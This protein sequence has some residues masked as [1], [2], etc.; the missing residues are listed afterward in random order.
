MHDSKSGEWALDKREHQRYLSLALP[1]PPH[2]ALEASWTLWTLLHDGMAGTAGWPTEPQ[3]TSDPMVTS[4]A[5][6][7]RPRVEAL[8]THPWALELLGSGPWQLPGVGGGEFFFLRGGFMLTPWGS[9]RWGTALPSDT[10]LPSRGEGAVRELVVFFCGLEWTH[11]ITLPQPPLRRA[12][13]GSKGGSTGRDPGSGSER[14]PQ[15]RLTERRG[16]SSTAQVATLVPKGDAALYVGGGEE[17]PD[18]AAALVGRCNGTQE[19]AVTLRRRLV[20]TG[21][22]RLAGVGALYLLRRGVAYEGRDK[23]WGSWSCARPP[24]APTASPR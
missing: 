21:P 19:N 6:Y 12:R 22:Y 11:S 4:H 23:A 8:A 15:V 24:T 16:S 7:V 17:E 13:G 3:R 14:T 18:A 20:G 5:R 9:A 10:D 1:P 2:C